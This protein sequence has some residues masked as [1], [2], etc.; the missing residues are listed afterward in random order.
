MNGINE[1]GSGGFAIPSGKEYFPVEEKDEDEG[2]EEGGDGG[3]D[4]IGEFLGDLQEGRVTLE[5]IE[6]RRG[7]YHAVPLVDPLLPCSVLPAKQRRQGNHCKGRLTFI[8]S[9][10]HYF[11]QWYIPVTI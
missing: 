9:I 2:E 6:G 10:I 3:E 4:L 8:P 5:L 7:G 11:P 1:G